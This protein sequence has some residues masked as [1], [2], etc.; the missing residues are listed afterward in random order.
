MFPLPA[1]PSEAGLR[2]TRRRAAWNF[3]RE[4]A[5]IG[6]ALNWLWGDSRAEAANFAT[7]HGEIWERVDAGLRRLTR[8]TPPPS[9]EA[10]LRDLL[11]AGAVPGYTGDAAAQGNVAPYKRAQVSRPTDAADCPW[12]AAVLPTWGPGEA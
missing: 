3:E 5:A 12:L 4:R 1:P 9:Q 8:G 7:D 11:R 6:S 10:A 2:D